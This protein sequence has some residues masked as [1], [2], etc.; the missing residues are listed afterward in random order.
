VDDVSTAVGGTGA[1]IVK[2]G[3]ITDSKLA[4]GAVGA[5]G[6]IATGSTDSRSVS[7]RFADVMSVKDYGAI[8]D[9]VADDTAAIQ[10][11]LNDNKGVVF[12]SG[13]YAISTQI[14][15]RLG[16]TITF[17]SDSELKLTAPFFHAVSFVYDGDYNQTRVENLSID[18]NNQSGANGL[19]VGGSGTGDIKNV[20]INNLS[21]KNALRNPDHTATY[22]GGG[23]GLMIETDV[24]NIQVVNPRFE[25]CTAGFAA[26]SVTANPADVL[27]VIN[28]VATECMHFAEFLGLSD[29]A[30]LP[31]SGEM[32][33]IN[34]I[35]GYGYNVGKGESSFYSGSGSFDAAEDT[36][37]I[38]SERGRHVTWKGF[39]IHNSNSYGQ[40]GSVV[41]G[42]GFHLNFEG[43]MIGDVSS[44]SNGTGSDMLL[45]IGGGGTPPST[46][47][48][49]STA[50]CHKI[51]LTG[52]HGTTYICNSPPGVSTGHKGFT[53]EFKFSSN[54]TTQLIDV[55]IARADAYMSAYNYNT[56]SLYSGS[57]NIITSNGNAMP[58]DG[59]VYSGFSSITFENGLLLPSTTVTGTN[60]S[61]RLSNYQEGDWTPSAA[62][63]SGVMTVN[64]A[65]YERVGR[66]VTARASVSFDGTV[67][68]SG[69]SI[70]QL[71]FAASIN[72]GGGGFVAQGGGGSV[73]HL[74]LISSGTV[75]LLDSNYNHLTYTTI[76]ANTIT[77]TLVYTVS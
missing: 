49:S 28:P 61:N 23:R 64:S 51:N 33:G 60:T 30:L 6:V 76:G 11:A 8:G 74:N 39:R 15:I 19:G 77:F 62:N 32:G 37:A 58:S 71:P 38:I 53:G 12:P 47:P 26:Q 52:D 41:R 17:D 54:P 57:F 46:S 5:T 73:Q 40:I 1:I 25:N 31:D 55:P 56:G 35:G 14:T 44:I 16:S 75:A 29:F 43:D 65:T 22:N 59:L 9:G 18:C 70:S 4:T 50:V 3:G 63:Y 13:T 67:D 36:G 72:N 7:D 66:I 42:T 10:A 48:I 20:Q 2:D 27:T 68:G 45:P 21:V 24:Y 34:I 69:A